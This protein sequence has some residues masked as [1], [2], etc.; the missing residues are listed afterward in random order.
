[1]KYFNWGILGTGYVARKFVLS[2]RY[3]MK[4][5]AV[6]V[7]SR[8][9]SNAG[10][11]ADEFN[12]AEAGSYESIVQNNSIDGFYIATPPSF[13]HKHALMCINSGR[14][15]L[16]EKPFAINY[17]Q[18][19]QVVE[20]ARSKSVFCMEAMWV[21]FLPLIKY[22]KKIIDKGDIGDIKMFTGNFCKV[23]PNSRKN[24]IYDSGLGGGALLHRAVY[25]I[26]LAFHL[27]GVPDKIH[28]DG[29]IGE[30][31]VDEQITAN[32]HYN[33]GAQATMYASLLTN[34]PNDFII[35]GTKA[36]VYINTPI[37]RPFRM[38][39][40]PVKQGQEDL[41]ASSRLESI[42]ESNIVHHLYQRVNPVRSA[43]SNLRKTKTIFYKGNGYHYQADE[44]ISC[45]EKG[46]LESPAM[47][48]G[49]SLKIMEAVDSIKHQMTTLFE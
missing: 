15:V 19:Q 32:F 40:M 14:P 10:K 26:S 48:W 6:A 30:T 33:K 8:S 47:P 37:Y 42:K 41:L 25:P 35:M 22:L 29:L 18:A 34:S 46:L 20:A 11:F 2:L 23:T 12:I 44:V 43:L 31:G 7:A 9:D 16:V 13:H 5:Q 4:S 36:N 38:R 45:V 17:Q 24:N 3:S 27:I 21:R 1:M 39:I 49:E 28:G